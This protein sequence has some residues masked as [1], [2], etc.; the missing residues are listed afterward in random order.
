MK[1]NG[2]LETALY[3]EDLH[4]AE[5]FY[6]E[7][8]GLELFATEY[9]RHL[10]FRCGHGMLL[11]FNP[12]ETLLGKDLPAH[13]AHGPQHVAFSVPAQELESWKEKLQQ[14][15]VTIDQEV[16]WPNGARSIY[17]A[18]PAGNSLELASPSLWNLRESA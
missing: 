14:H 18:D 13:G 6:R 8:L 16:D 5:A 9:P 15:G 12:R 1:I 17:F 7:V 4:A 10:F 3:A 2:V 11:I